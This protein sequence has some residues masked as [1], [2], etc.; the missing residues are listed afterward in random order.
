M[1]RWSERLMDLEAVVGLG[2]DGA[3]PSVGECW[4]MRPRSAVV[5]V[6]HTLSP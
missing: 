2:L 4:E 1:W 3:G 5:G 6:I